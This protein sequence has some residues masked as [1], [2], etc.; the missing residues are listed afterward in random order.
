[1][2]R[3][4]PVVAVAALNTLVPSSPYALFRFDDL[5][6]A[7]V[8][9][10]SN[11]L[12]TPVTITGTTTSVLS[13]NPGAF[14]SAGDNRIL[15]TSAEAHALLRIDTLGDSQYLVFGYGWYRSANPATIGSIFGHS[16]GAT[17][18]GFGVQ[19]HNDAA[20]KLVWK[21]NGSSQTTPFSRGVSS[22]NSAWNSH[23]W[24]IKK[25]GDGFVSGLFENATLVD[26]G[27]AL[28]GT[29]ATAPSLKQSQ[30]LS[31]FKTST[32]NN[33]PLA[34]GIQIRGLLFARRPITDFGNIATAAAQ[35]HANPGHTPRVWAGL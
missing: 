35:F 1:M 16:E 3:V 2:S 12:S 23:L 6:G 14:T 20:I 22:L 33:Q 13:G 34:S 4:Q 15:D 9:V 24:Y 29:A 10:K 31:L 8:A 26:S 28:A 7:T 11:V 21:P 27:T 30:G 17:E 18:G 5:A 32:S 25:S 19:Q